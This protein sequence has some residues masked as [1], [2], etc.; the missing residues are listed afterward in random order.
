MYRTNKRKFVA[1]IS[2]AAA[3]T[4]GVLATG[5]GVASASPGHHSRHGHH[6]STPFSKGSKFTGGLAMLEGGVGGTVTALTPTSITIQNWAG[7]SGTFAI[8]STTTIL[9]GGAAGTAADLAVGEHVRIAP[10]TTA[11]MTAATIEVVLAEV[12]GKVTAVSGN[13]ITVALHN[14]LTQTVVVGS[15]TTYTLG[16][17]ASTLA[18]VTVGVF[19]EA[20][21]TV[22]TTL[23]VLNAVTVRIHSNV[24]SARVVG[25]VT[26]VSGNVIT[27]QVHNGLSETV[28]VSSTTTYM[29]AGAAATLADVTAGEFIFAVGTVDTT[30]NT[31]DAANVFIASLST[32]GTDS[33]GDSDGGLSLGL[34]LGLGGGGHHHGH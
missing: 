30:A 15:T 8:T 22:N 23:N 20:K 19:I 31:L 6:N 9:V 17:V 13:N 5:V 34:G 33:D 14:G 10:S 18:A 12:E 16:G 25:K 26:G 29:K 24:K 4:F 11:T 1:R 28:T 21:G 7:L 27:I 2:V 3:L 32:G